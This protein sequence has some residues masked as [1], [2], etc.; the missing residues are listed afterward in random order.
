ML[1]RTDAATGAY[2]Y[3]DKRRQAGGSTAALPLFSASSCGMF[4]WSPEENAGM[5]CRKGQLSD[6]RVPPVVHV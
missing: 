2:W 5:G 1:S 6:P 3:P 4:G